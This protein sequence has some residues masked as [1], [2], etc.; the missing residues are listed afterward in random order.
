MLRLI[1]VD[2]RVSREAVGEQGLCSGAAL[3]DS[4]LNWDLRLARAETPE[5]FIT[6]KI[7]LEI[8]LLTFPSIHSP[9]HPVYLQPPFPVRDRP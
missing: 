8:F 4:Q 7:D 6:A 1:M 2:E 9:T 5:N 3:S